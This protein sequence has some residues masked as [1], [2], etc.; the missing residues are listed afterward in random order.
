MVAGLVL[1]ELLSNGWRASAGLWTT[2][3]NL[4]LQLCSA[5]LWVGVYGLLSRVRWA[6]TLMYFFG[7]AGASQ[8]L[9]TPS[10][11]HGAGH[12][13]H[14]ATILSHGLLVISGLWTV[15]VEGYRPAIRDAVTAFA[16]LNGYA[17][18]LYPVNLL[19]GGNYMYLVDRPATASLLDLF[20]DWPWYLLLVE[21]IALGLFLLMALPFRSRS[22]ELGGS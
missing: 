1:A 14:L 18:M 2:G 11:E 8:A 16:V 7:V 3:A 21:L 10:I 4:P 22:R 5:V 13:T 20:P 15:I 9:L 19:L 12:I 6:Y 17:L